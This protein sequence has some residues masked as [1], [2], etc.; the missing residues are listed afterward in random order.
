MN[1]YYY[2]LAMKCADFKDKRDPLIKMH[3]VYNIILL[4][5]GKH[6]STD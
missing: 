6:T 1:Y 2:L 5:N 4:P 3:V